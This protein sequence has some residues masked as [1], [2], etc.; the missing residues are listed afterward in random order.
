MSSAVPSPLISSWAWWRIVVGT[1]LA[2]LTAVSLW[3]HNGA[4][5]VDVRGNALVKQTMNH[6][7]KRRRAGDSC[8]HDP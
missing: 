5:K 3:S 8:Q 7:I 1:M 4:V 6:S 2:D